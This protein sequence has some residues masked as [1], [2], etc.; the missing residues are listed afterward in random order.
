MDSHHS[1]HVNAPATGGAVPVGKYC[2]WILLQ[3]RP[4]CRSRK[5]FSPLPPL[6]CYSWINFHVSSY[7]DAIPY[8]LINPVLFWL[9]V[10]LN[11]FFSVFLACWINSLM[12]KAP[13]ECKCLSYTLC[14]TSL[15]WKDAFPNGRSLGQNLVQLHDFGDSSVSCG[16]ILQHFLWHVCFSGKWIFFECVLHPFA[17]LFCC[18]NTLA[19]NLAKTANLRSV[20]GRIHVK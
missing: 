15:V 11:T 10:S 5:G 2:P 19:T 8:F 3:K 17:Q 1:V 14:W 6:S 16:R 20:Y 4:L 7:S 13:L 18:I 9:T 12:N